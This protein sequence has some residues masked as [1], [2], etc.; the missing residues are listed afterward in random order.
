LSSTGPASRDGLAAA[1]LVGIAPLFLD[2]T[3]AFFNFPTFFV[4]LGLK[5]VR[6]DSIVV[7]AAVLEKKLC[8]GLLSS[9]FLGGMG[10]LQPTKVAH[11]APMKSALINSFPQAK[12]L[13]A[14]GGY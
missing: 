6:L 8:G 3:F 14:V 1:G 11:S 5:E 9:I 2:G 7:V 4:T 10:E 13:S 12:S